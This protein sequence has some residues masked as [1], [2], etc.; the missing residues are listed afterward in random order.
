MKGVL[1]MSE[2]NN[3]VPTEI[4]DVAGVDTALMA[5]EPMQGSEVE[6]IALPGLDEVDD[7]KKIIKSIRD[8]FRGFDFNAKDD[9]GT[10][11][12]TLD[13]LAEYTK[14]AIEDIRDA[15]TKSVAETL[16]NQGAC[17][18]RFWCVG[19]A[20]DSA[21]TNASYGVNAYNQLATSLGK[22]VGFIYKWRSVA[23]NLTLS[24]AYLLGIRGVEQ[25][26]VVNLAYNIHDDN[27]RNALI[28]GFV[29]AV[30]DGADEQARL[31]A[32][33]KLKQAINDIPHNNLLET[34]NTDPATG[35]SDVEVTPE[36]TAALKL[37]ADMHRKFAPI[38]DEKFF[39]RIAT[40]CEDFFLMDN[41]PD[42]EDHLERLRE[43]AEELKTMLTAAMNMTT[44]AIAQLD[45]ITHCELTKA[46]DNDQD[47]GADGQIV[48]G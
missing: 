16:L 30:V 10:R 12:P 33:R 20:L 34:G 9:F 18:G 14:S 11:F 46:E 47:G 29:S 15:R 36:F 3:N 17:I 5:V 44:D 13:A 27:T 2:E 45:S 19:K 37:F 7:D 32:V 1:E 22:S 41:V 42:C 39:D 38:A 28:S 24:Q 26:T 21:L 31:E 25:T 23:K 4:E 6:S 8:V 40:V 43:Q 35:G 48:Q